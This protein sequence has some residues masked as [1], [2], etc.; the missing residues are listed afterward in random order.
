MRLR[1]MLKTKLDGLIITKTIFDCKGSI[2][3]DR[4]LLEKN[5]IVAGEKVQVLNYDNG[6]RLETYVI[7]E[8]RHSR[9]IALY[10]PAAH[11]G[12]VGDKLC[13]LSYVLV[14]DADLKKHKS[15]V[16]KVNKHNRPVK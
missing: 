7:A 1:Q 12:S 13:V 6:F 4:A 8:P 2:G 15:R 5:D 14:D 16:I 11:C 3:I 10:G 9:K